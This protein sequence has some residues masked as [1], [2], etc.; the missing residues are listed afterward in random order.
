MTTYAGFQFGYYTRIGADGERSDDAHPRSDRHLD[1]GAAPRDGRV[2]GQ[3]EGAHTACARA[4]EP[5][6]LLIGG[7]MQ[8]APC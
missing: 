5:V 2:L 8:S 3:E 6:I 1:R 4:G 7:R